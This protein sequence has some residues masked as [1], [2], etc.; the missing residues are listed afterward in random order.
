[1][2]TFIMVRHGQSETNV[3]KAFTGQ[4][5][6][7][8]TDMGREQAQRMAAY[9]NQYKVDKIYASSLDRAV[10]TA[11]Y[12]ARTQNCPIE[13]CDAL[14]EINAGVWQGLTFEE[15][16]RRYPHTHRDWKE[17]FDTA[18]PDGGETCEQ[19]YRRV[20]QW[21]EEI[22]L[23]TSEETV[24]MVSHAIPIRMMEKYILNIP[25][26][27]IPWAPNASVTV[28][29]YDGTFHPVVRGYSDHLGDMQTNLPKNI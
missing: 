11:S 17:N 3:K 8:L 21:F 25:A 1:M 24:C 29:T 27:E 28:Y 19:V 14:R 13:R 2:R 20:T 22:L 16:S 7:P 4:I 23:H 6:A 10:E 15:V 18:A 26:Q 5:D 12:I 9:V